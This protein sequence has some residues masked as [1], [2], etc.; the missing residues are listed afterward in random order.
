MLMSDGCERWW[1]PT[2]MSLRSWK[3]CNGRNV[4]NGYGVCN[5]PHLRRRRQRRMFDGGWP[6]PTYG[7]NVFFDAG[8]VA[9]IFF[10][11]IFA[12]YIPQTQF[13]G[14]LVG[15]NKVNNKQGFPDIRISSEKKKQS[16]I[17]KLKKLWPLLQVCIK[18]HEKKNILIR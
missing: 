6:K 12:S 3:E 1:H 15:V 10:F 8:K 4:K 14:A 13:S 16:E 18:L 9:N 17:F 11:Y 5:I 2:G 7:L